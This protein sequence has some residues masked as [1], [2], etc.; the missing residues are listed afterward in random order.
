M[1]LIIGGTTIAV[2]IMA[3]FSYQVVRN[4]TL[5]NLKQNV[6]LEVKQG[7]DEVDKWLVVRKTEVKTSA[8]T[9]AVRAF[10]RSLDWATI[11]PYL[12]AEL[13]QINEFYFLLVA[14]QKGTLYNTATD[15]LA[16]VS[17]SDRPHFRGAMAGKVAAYDPVISRT[18]AHPSIPVTAPVRQ[19]L[20]NTGAPV[21]VFGGFVKVDRLTQVIGELQ[22]GEGSYAFAINSK[23]KAIIH[24]DKTLMSTA[25][26]PAP[27]LI[28]SAPPKLAEIVQKMVNRHQGIE[29]ITIDN[30]QKYIAFLPFREANWSVALVIP[31]KNIESQLQL[32]DGIAIAVMG[33][34]CTMIAVLWWVQSSEQTQ[35]KKSKIAADAANQAKSEFLANMSHELRTPLNGILGYAQILSRAKTWGDKERNGINII[36]QCGSHLLTLINDILDLSKI[37]ARRM[38]LFPTEFHFLGFLEGVAE[39]SRIRAEQKDITFTYKPDPALP[40]GIRAD[41]KRLRQVLI[42]LLGNAIKF[43]DNGGVTFIIEVMEKDNQSSTTHKI[44]FTIK[45]T[46]VGMTPAQLQTIFL[47]FEQVGDGKKQAEGTGLGLAITKTIVELMNS[48]IQVESQYGQGSMFSFEVVLPEA[49]EW[50]QTSHATQ[51]GTIIGYQGEKRRVLVVDDR[52]ENRSVIVSLLQPLGFEVI[53]ATNGQEGWELAA[54]HHPDV[55]IT[56]LMMPVMN[57]YELLRQLRAS[58]L[59]EVVAIASSAS[60]FESNQ[61]ESLDAGANLFLP[62]PIQA[63]V[64]LKILQKY[65]QLE[66]IYE[67]VD[68]ATDIAVSQVSTDEIISPPDEV[69]QQL[70]TLVQDGDVQAI[71]ELAEQLIESDQKLVPFA[72]QIKQLASSFQIKRLESFIGNGE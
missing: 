7:R 66:W 47:P 58:E 72:Q 34:A 46:G 57:G 22:Y 62:K 67:Q 49:Q 15:G 36:H 60:V 70:R 55:V 39:L 38:E 10:G 63:D 13:Q 44:R 37:E 35:L 53:E 27:S 42:N 18:T 16:G 12:Q 54:N 25:E 59:K 43:T 6:L 19:S 40:I 64:L 56:D 17:I 26:K 32:L 69:L 30:T 5:N 2:S 1:R 52:W 24:P 20:N 31:R 68:S 50:A 51:Q 41:E 48:Q 9:E 3:Y 71:L 4:I 33:L 45:D 23:G 11:E 8:N 65:L 29:L 21:G 14:D 61:H 28:K